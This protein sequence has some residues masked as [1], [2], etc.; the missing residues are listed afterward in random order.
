MTEKTDRRIRKTKAQLR[1]GLARL[2]KEKSINEITVRELVDEADIN[3]STFY[4]H[5]ND[6]YHLL[7]SIENDLFE[8]LRR[9]VDTHAVDPLDGDTFPF[10]A[11]IFSLVEQ[12][13]DI[14]SALLGDHGDLAFVRR[15]EQ[16]IESHSLSLLKNCIPENLDDI[17]M[18]YS[19]CLSGCVGL[20]KSW[21]SG[22]C[23]STPA[24]MA[25]LTY[26]IFTTAISQYHV[27]SKN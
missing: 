19:F 22:E 14:C 13:R 7:E 10:I 3:R 23:S 1:T 8:E 6:I 17:C 21:L 24:H 27:L 20:I 11:D 4:L 5:Y 18:T 25:D 2:M 15:I 16:F 12:N 26:R 9:I